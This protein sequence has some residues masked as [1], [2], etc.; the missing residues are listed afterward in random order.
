MVKSDSEKDELAISTSCYNK[1]GDM[2]ARRF[3]SS[4]HIF[5]K[6]SLKKDGDVCVY[7]VSLE[8][9]VDRD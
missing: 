9:N 2:E 4:V 8:E 7:K 1:Y 5:S 3:Y 6:N